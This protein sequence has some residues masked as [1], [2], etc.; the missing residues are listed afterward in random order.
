ME[1]TEDKIGEIED[2]AGELT[3]KIGTKNEKKNIQ[4]LETVIRGKYISS[5]N[6]KKEKT[7]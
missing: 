5:E 3:E 4:E 6:Y 2:K 1:I 7:K